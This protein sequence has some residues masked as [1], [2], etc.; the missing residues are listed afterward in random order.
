LIIDVRANAL[1]AVSHHGIGACTAAT[2]LIVDIHIQ[3]PELPI[4]AI[5]AEI[6]I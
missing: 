2:P 6:L 4:T 5:P 3:Q 1:L